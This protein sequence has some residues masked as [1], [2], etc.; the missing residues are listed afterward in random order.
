MSLSTYF[1]KQITQYFHK[2]ISAN[3]EYSLKPHIDPLK[4]NFQGDCSGL[5]SAPVRKEQ[6]YLPSRCDGQKTGISS[7]NIRF[8]YQKTSAHPTIQPL[9]TTEKR[10]RPGR[11]PGTT[12]LLMLDDVT[13]LLRG[14]QLHRG[15]FLCT[16]P[17]H[18]LCR[19][20]GS[21]NHALYV[22]SAVQPAHRS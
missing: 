8:I 4:T 16:A 21:G 11:R 13:K 9:P 14:C 7:Y 20:H 17:G 15:R 6:R 1:R 12:S 5:T 3:P 2:Q 18:R 22:A 10:R 19:H